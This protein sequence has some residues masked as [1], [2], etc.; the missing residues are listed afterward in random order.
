M[1]SDDDGTRCD[2]EQSFDGTITFT[3]YADTDDCTEEIDIAFTCN[4]DADGQ[5]D[6]TGDA[7]GGPGVGTFGVGNIGNFVECKAS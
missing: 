7:S 3:L 2:S 1:C 5:E 4:W 6:R